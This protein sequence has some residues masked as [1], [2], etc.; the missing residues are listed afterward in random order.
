MS[1]KSVQWV[2][3]AF[4]AGRRRVVQWKSVNEG[5][6][7]ASGASSRVDQL[8]TK[9]GPIGTPNRVVVVEPNVHTRAYFK[10]IL[11]STNDFK[12]AA[13]FS[14]ANEALNGVPHLRPDVMLLS[15]RRHDLNNTKCISLF[16]R[17][18][19]GLKV[20]VVLG[21]FDADTLE[22]SM[23]AGA[24]HCLVKPVHAAQC[25]ATLNFTVCRPTEIEPK[26]CP[27]G[28]EPLGGAKARKC[29]SLSGREQEVMSRL[30]GGRLY[31]EIAF[32]LRMSEAL[33][34]KHAHKIYQKFQVQ[35]RAEA[36][37]VWFNQIG[38][39]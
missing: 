24:D 27:L 3:K 34:R 29:E 25:L 21:M 5:V 33:V 23:R 6:P 4:Q 7:V 1:A 20:I 30:A 31:K 16:K 9:C 17:L 14:N 19:V 13:D 28:P 26:P 38:K 15:V 2:A 32:E 22:L 18:L 8:G 12:L 36:I 11:Q 37:G 39:F 35:N 10:E